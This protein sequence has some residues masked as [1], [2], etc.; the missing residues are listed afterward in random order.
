MNNY[1]KRLQ[2]ISLFILFFLFIIGF[3][4]NSNALLTNLHNEKTINIQSSIGILQNISTQNQR[5]INYL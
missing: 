1:I 2:K 3:V 5:G 4:Y